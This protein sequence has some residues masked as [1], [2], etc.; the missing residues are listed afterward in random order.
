MRL[1]LG[2][3]EPA[4]QACTT[5]HGA[6]GASNRPRRVVH[7]I[8]IGIGIVVERTLPV[9][10][11]R[12]FTTAKVHVSLAA[13][14]CLSELERGAVPN[15][16]F[17]ALELTSPLNS[18]SVTIP[19][20][21]LISSSGAVSGVESASKFAVSGSRG[22]VPSL[23]VRKRPGCEGLR[24]ILASCRAFIRCLAL[25]DTNAPCWEH[26]FDGTREDLDRMSSVLLLRLV[27]PPAE[28]CI[29]RV[30][31]IHTC[32][33]Y[34][35]ARS[36]VYHAA[37]HRCL[38]VK[39]DGA[40]AARALERPSYPP[41]GPLELIVYFHTLGPRH[42]RAARSVQHD[43]DA[44]PLMAIEPLVAS[45]PIA[46]GVGAATSVYTTM[47][48]SDSLSL[49]RINVPLDHTVPA[50][51]LPPVKSSSSAP[52]NA[53]VTT[54]AA[55][56]VAVT[57]RSSSSQLH[58]PGI[59]GHRYGS[60]NVRAFIDCN[61]NFVNLIVALAIFSFRAA[62]ARA[63]R[64]STL[65][66]G[67]RA[68]ECCDICSDLVL[69]RHGVACWIQIQFLQSRHQS[70]VR[71]HEFS[72]RSCLGISQRR[73]LRCVR[74][75]LGISQRRHLR[76]V[77]S[78]LGI[79]QRRHPP[80]AASAAVLAS[81][82]A[83]ICA[84]SALSWAASAAPSWHQPTPSRRLRVVRSCRGFSQR[85][86]L[87][88]IRSRRGFSQRRHLRVSAAVAASA[89]AVIS[90]SS[91]PSVRNAI[92]RLHPPAVAA[93]ANA[94]IC[95]FG[96]SAA[97]RGI[98]QRRHLRRFRC[99]RGISQRH[100]LR[101]F[102]CRR[103]ISQR[104]HLRRFRCR[105]GI[106]QAIIFAASAAVAASANAIIFAASAAV[107]ASANAIIFAASAAVAASANAIICAASAAVAAS[108]NAI[109]L[110]AS[111]AVA[112]SANA[113]PAPPP[114]LSR[115]SAN[116]VIRSA[117]AAIAPQPTPIRLRFFRR[118]C[119]RRRRRLRRS[120]MQR[121][122]S[123]SAV[124]PSSSPEL[125]QAPTASTSATAETVVNNLFLWNFILMIKLAIGCQKTSEDV[126]YGCLPGSYGI[127]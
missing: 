70:A 84:S 59:G 96:G 23:G 126:N 30:R 111:A 53:T 72:V 105:R 112:A 51:A 25:K 2:C 11:P 35:L 66:V 100:H 125:L 28:V 38:F 29:R 22:E 64:A 17:Q 47:V 32:H 103:G 78:C 108:A 67:K 18:K 99:R 122:S 55:S 34:G 81:A 6:E 24:R 118:C 106:S 68:L 19:E 54:P 13:E 7:G 94:V 62:S 93:S 88:V 56:R 74:S 37:K 43:L 39:A 60:H 102:R 98:S 57:P 1:L 116:A 107:A 124:I 3:T 73:H 10:G 113:S 97:C 115:P 5:G 41:V 20:M 75:C 49:V 110:A 48:S 44:P 58:T 42:Q 9:S 91:A 63:S 114:Q 79:S 31:R 123:R 89:N 92:L 50:E 101:C 127:S 95:A 69:N 65:I 86:H 27:Q 121:A 87:R 52:V 119:G 36:S 109:I 8:G 46:V 4:K 120:L 85:R 90:P 14:R 77:R 61:R 33:R 40:I 82:N 71:S 83:V 21:F 45:S 76:C 80:C 15:V 104:H 12:L 26:I 117:S 16:S